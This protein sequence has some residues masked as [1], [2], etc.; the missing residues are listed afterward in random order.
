MK[1]KTEKRPV[2]IQD[3]LLGARFCYKQ[4]GDVDRIEIY[5]DDGMLPARCEVVFSAT[6]KKLL[7]MRDELKRLR[8]EVKELQ[9]SLR[10]RGERTER[11]AD[12][13][14]E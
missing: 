5:I 4:N 2:R 12:V 9:P 6:L 8:K 11:F 10:S 14:D 1:K 7:A 13:D 3:P